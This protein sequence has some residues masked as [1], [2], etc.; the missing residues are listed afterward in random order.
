MTN[1]K[2]PED[3]FSASN[4]E[5][6]AAGD[7]AALA[8]TGNKEV[9]TGAGADAGTTEPAAAPQK[10]QGSF[11]ASTWAALIVG[12]LL[13]IVL[14]IF[15]MQ[16]QQEVPMNFLGWSGQ[17]PAGI[18]YLMFTIGGALIMALVGVWRMLELR[19]QLRKQAEG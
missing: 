15:I 12:F 3:D 4:D 11:A 17:F 16:N 13:L 7:N 9:S 5:A 6:T 8:E 19:R 2:Y 14:I 18:A 10:A 1:P